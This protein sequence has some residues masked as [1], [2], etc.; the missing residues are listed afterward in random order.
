MNKSG[1]AGAIIGKFAVL[2]G[3]LAFLYTI[4]SPYYLNTAF[5]LS[6]EM[7]VAFENIFTPAIKFGTTMILIG[8]VAFM[9]YNMK[10]GI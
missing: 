2:I 6:R 3:S 1:Q 7:I 10:G 4:W 8:I 9:G 5:G